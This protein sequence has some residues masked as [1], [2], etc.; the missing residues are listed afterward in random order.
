MIF[1]KQKMGGSRMKQLT[2]LRVF[3]DVATPLDRVSDSIGS[4]TGAAI[5]LIAVAF[6]AVAVIL[7]K[8]DKKKKK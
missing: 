6:A 7:L 1:I 8:L 5:A 3:L 2:W 4:G